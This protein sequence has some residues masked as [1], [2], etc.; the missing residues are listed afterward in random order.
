M[1]ARLVEG[2][3]LQVPPRPAKVLARVMETN[4]AVRENKDAD[5]GTEPRA[6][7]LP[8]ADAAWQEEVLHP[9]LG[10]RLAGDA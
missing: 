2:G 1:Q 8:A 7:V 4:R 6:E 9:R 10:D 5:A 3:T